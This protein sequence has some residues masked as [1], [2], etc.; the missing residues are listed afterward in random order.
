M[1]VT[2]KLSAVYWDSVV[3][4]LYQENYWRLTD[5]FPAILVC[6]PFSFALSGQLLS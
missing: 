6:T 4:T 2:D 3:G 1:E 5:F